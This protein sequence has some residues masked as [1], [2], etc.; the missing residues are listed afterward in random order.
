MKGALERLLARF[1]GE[2]RFEAAN[3]PAWIEPG[4]GVTVLL[5]GSPVGVFGELS[6]SESAS[7]KLR[8][9]CVLAELDAACLQ[10][11]PLRQPVLQELSRFQAV[12]R[13]FSFVFPDAVTWGAV[14]DSVRGTGVQEMGE[15][16][17]LEIFR[18]PKGKAVA[19]GSYSLLTRV[20]FQSRERTLTEEDLSGWS[21]AVVSALTGLGGIQRA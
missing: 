12:A 20:V 17:P 9:S 19:A 1:A 5:N 10:A 7:R 14:E 18:D 6:A 21:E 8:Q 4:R 2:V 13:D 16:Q 11:T 15:V 3:L